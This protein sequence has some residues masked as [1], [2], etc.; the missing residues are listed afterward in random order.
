MRKVTNVLFI[1]GLLALVCII[2]YYNSRYM[3]L[4]VAYVGWGPQDYVAQKLHPENFKRNWPSG[5][6]I[7]DHSML[8]RVYYYLA[9]YLGMNPT[10]T[11]YPYMFV[12][13]LLFFI[14]VA[15]LSQT[16]FQNK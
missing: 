16:L 2:F 12:Q 10:T 6:L 1:T 5:I 11:M 3:K 9:R 13:T 8:M 15:F 4:N 7:Y 14:S